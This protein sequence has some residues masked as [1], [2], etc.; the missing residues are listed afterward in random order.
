MGPFNPSDVYDFYNETI[1]GSR[2]P[3]F[4]GLR[5]MVPPIRAAWLIGIRTGAYTENTLDLEMAEST[6]PGARIY[7][8]YGPAPEQSAL[9]TAFDYVLNPNATTEP[10]LNVSVISNSWGGSDST[11]TGWVQATQQAEARGITVLAASGDSGDNPS[12][13]KECASPRQNVCF[14]ASL[15]Y[16]KYGTIAVGERRLRLDSSLNLETNIVWNISEMKEGGPAGSTGGIS[17]VY[18]EPSWQANTSANDLIFG[19]GRGVPD[20]AAVANNT[21]LTLS[22]QGYQLQASNASLGK[23]FEYAWGTSIASPI[24]AGIFAD[25]DQVLAHFGN[26]WIGFG[27]PQLVLDRECDVR[28]ATLWAGVRVHPGCWEHLSLDSAD[29]AVL[30]RDLKGPIMST[31]PDSGTIW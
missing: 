10:L 30:R 5:S 17:T 19:A 7:N 6:A 11:D 23:L 3:K 9:D 16:D 1:P 13:P 26:G 15:A 12:S 18:P 25:A 24:E 20:I 21:I 28:A 4:S 2:M 31:Q 29:V 8:V 27:D 22:I 14:P